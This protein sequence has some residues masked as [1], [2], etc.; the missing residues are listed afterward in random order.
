MQPIS[1][2][3]QIMKHTQLFLSALIACAL[4]SC[5]PESIVPMPIPGA[6]ADFAYFVDDYNPL[7]ISFANRSTNGLK[8]YMWEYGD[9]TFYQSKEQ[10]TKVYSA[11]GTYT[12][13]LICKDGNGYSYE[14]KKQITVGNPGIDPG[15]DPGTVK[16]YNKVYIAGFELYDIYTSS[17]TEFY[18]YFDI[19]LVDLMG[20]QRTYTTPR[21]SFKLKKSNLPY[22]QYFNEPILIGSAPNAFDYYR[23]ITVKGYYSPYPNTDGISTIVH[24]I[25]NPSDLEYQTEYILK[26]E[27]G[28]KELGVLLWYE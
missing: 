3:N 18:T 8:V 15:D 9:N 26:N 1:N 23:I 6:K 5:K 12:V 13:T 16:S 28:E 2:T 19:T 22:E 17:Y 21:S 7:K 27:N 11:A 24:I 4:F 20:T 25:D 14:C 10:V